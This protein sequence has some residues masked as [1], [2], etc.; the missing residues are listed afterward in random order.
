MTYEPQQLEGACFSW[1]SDEDNA[2]YQLNPPKAPSITPYTW[3]FGRVSSC[4]DKAIDKVVEKTTPG[5]RTA[6]KA[7]ATYNR[8]D[9][10]GQEGHISG[11]LRH[12][13]LDEKIEWWGWWLEDLAFDLGMTDGWERGVDLGIYLHNRLELT[14]REAIA[15]EMGM[16][17][18]EVQSFFK[19]AERWLAK[20]NEWLQDNLELF[21]R[22]IERNGYS[23]RPEFRQLFR[24]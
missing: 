22:E 24:F 13:S 2:P 7:V 9:K 6:L 17:S 18:N 23:V 8:L 5:L 11:P 16:T 3:D 19:R 12:H 4:G 15:E 21:I 1:L 14:T 20:H 10:V